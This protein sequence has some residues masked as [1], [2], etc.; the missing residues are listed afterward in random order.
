MNKSTIPTK[1][2]DYN[3]Y[4]E[5]EVLVGMDAELKLPSL[6]AVT[7]EISGAGVAGT[8]EDPTPGY[9][10]SLET[11]IK[12][13]TISEESSRL[14]IP[15]AHTL[16]ARA[17]QTRHDP[18]SGVNTQEGVKV[19]M[20]GVTKSYDLGTFKQGESTETTVKLELSYLKI[21]RGST[22]VVELDKFNHIFVVEGT[23]YMKEIRDLI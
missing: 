17:A 12:F 19:V 3:L 23:D 7:S 16:T 5:G 20:R 9:F 14:A 15:K 21:T 18:A 22:V 2:T 10:G 6:E 11:E 4:N 1:L 8:M 13:R